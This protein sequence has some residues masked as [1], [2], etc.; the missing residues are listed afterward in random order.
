MTE[1]RTVVAAGRRNWKLKTGIRELSIMM[2]ML[3]ILSSEYEFMK[4]SKF[5]NMNTKFLY[6]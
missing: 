6:T 4:V 5:I 3:Y 2:K 1:I